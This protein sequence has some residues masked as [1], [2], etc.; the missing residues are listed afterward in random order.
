MKQKRN[1]PQQWKYWLSKINPKTNQLYTEEDAK[2]YVSSFR[3]WSKFYWMKRI[4][5][6]TDQLYTEEDANIQ[7]S[8]I[9]KEMSLKSVI[10][11][12]YN[13]N[14]LFVFIKFYLF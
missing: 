11:S 10:I 2:E 7:V 8:I 9:Q 3:K 13:Y 14:Y 12:R 1:S 4:N 6:K 5:P